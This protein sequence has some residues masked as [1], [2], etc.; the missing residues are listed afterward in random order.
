MQEEKVY[1]INPNEILVEPRQRKKIKE[2]S[3]KDLALSIQELGQIHP[4]LCYLNE[5][6]KPTLIVGERRLR[7]CQL[8]DLPYKY[9]LKE[10]VTD[11]LL[12]RQIELEENLQR[13]DL[14]WIE[15]VEAKKELHELYQ[16]RYGL[17]TQGA[18]GGHKLSDTAKHLGE[19]DGLVSGD[20]ELALWAEEIPE[21]AEAKNKTTAKKIVD[22]L[23]KGVKRRV[24]LKE[25]LRESPK[26]SE[27][28][29]P[30]QISSQIL[31]EYDKK[32]LLGRM[33]DVLE[34]RPFD[35]EVSFD[36]VLFDPPWGVN[37]DTV[38][39]ST[40]ASENFEDDSDMFLTQFP[41]WINLLY[42][43]MSENSHLYMFFG[44]VNHNF[45]YDI[46]EQEGFQV[47]RIP[48]IWHKK[49]THRTRNPEV[50][51]GRCYEPIAFA[52]KGKKLLFRQ[53]APDIIE[54]PSPTPNIKQEH[55]SAKHPDIYIEL[56]KRS[57]AP[58]DFVLDPMAGSGMSAIACEY[59]R[60]ELALNW[61]LIEE[62]ET[63]RDLQL[64]NLVKGYENIVRMQI[65]PPKDFKEL[66]P[67]SPEWLNYWKAHPKEQ[68]EMI[69]WTNEEGEN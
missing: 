62:K 23:K 59:L 16:L 40:G 19:S 4:G 14:E 26:E 48:L 11:K 3:L 10:E 65:T 36:I 29:S 31:L 2:K 12:L 46:L 55:P 53:G 50:W 47:N 56:L 66:N 68:N 52:R 38:S 61:T 18:K 69:A 30:E 39:K 5:E 7:A 37:Y 25:A 35:L 6:G 33:E 41:K 58:G 60:S 27:E 8:L 22:R 34:K 54:T 57:A 21:V 42:K 63:F 64:I 32:C 43:S 17:T 67:G 24:A 44:I 45:V 20:I 13:E 9:I 1:Q 51:P 15:E 49:G 28:N